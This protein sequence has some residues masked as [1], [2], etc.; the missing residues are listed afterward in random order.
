MLLRRLPCCQDCVAWTPCWM[1][2][3]ISTKSDANS[4]SDSAS[5][6]SSDTMNICIIMTFDV[7]VCSA[8]PK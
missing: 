6:F 8:L 1:I 4:R 7:L 3:R 2:D 5:S